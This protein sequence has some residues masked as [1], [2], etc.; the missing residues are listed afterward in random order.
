[1]IAAVEETFNDSTVPAI[2]INTFQ[3]VKS[4][5]SGLIPLPSF[6]KIKPPLSQTWHGDNFGKR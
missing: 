5:I 6:P 2:G 4:N 3:S 1:M